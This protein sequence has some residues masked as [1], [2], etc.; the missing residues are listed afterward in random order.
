MIGWFRA[1]PLAGGVSV[2][3]HVPVVNL[4]LILVGMPAIAVVL[5]WVLSGRE[6]P[7]TVRRAIE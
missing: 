1:S 7:A 2:L 5:G 6:R 4:A 3:G